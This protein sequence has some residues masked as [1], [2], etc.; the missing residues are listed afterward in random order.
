MAQHS[1]RYAAEHVGTLPN[2]KVRDIPYAQRNQRHRNVRS[3]SEKQDDSAIRHADFPT[4]I[5]LFPVMNFYIGARKYRP[6]D[7]AAAASTVNAKPFFRV[8]CVG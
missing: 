4:G 6:R 2:I 3:R 8:R 1:G 5:S 7:R